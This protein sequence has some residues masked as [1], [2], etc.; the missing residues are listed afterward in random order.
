MTFTHVPEIGELYGLRLGTFIAVSYDDEGN[1]RDMPADE[2]AKVWETFSGEDS[3]NSCVL[4][5][6]RIRGLA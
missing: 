6:M 2:W 4:E 3:V 5:I 1:P